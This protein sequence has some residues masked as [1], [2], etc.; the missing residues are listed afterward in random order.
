[1]V[2]VVRQG[3]H[4]TVLLG[5]IQYLVP[6]QPQVVDMA[7]EEQRPAVR[8]Q[9]VLAVLAEVA[10][11]VLAQVAQ[12]QVGKAI[13]GALVMLEILLAVAEAVLVVLD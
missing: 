12:E 13:M 7:H 1:L 6:L 10:V 11:V 4:Q 5:Q 3:H 8:G 2:L 9:V